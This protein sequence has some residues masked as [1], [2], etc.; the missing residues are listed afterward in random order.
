MEN[1]QSHWGGTLLYGV[2]WLICCGLLIVDVL[3]F[4]EASLDIMTK[5]R[6][7][8]IQNAAERQAAAEAIRSG[9][10]MQGI[11]TGLTLVGGIVAVA[12]AIG[13]E[14]YFRL[15]RKKGKLVQRVAKVVGILVLILIIFVLI[16]MLT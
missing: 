14:Y 6:A 10:E 13:F 15:G 2:A 8:R 1:N 12:G 5:I 4:R 16:Q 3:S 7:Q 9:Y 11:D